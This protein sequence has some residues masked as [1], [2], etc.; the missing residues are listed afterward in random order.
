MSSHF[1]YLIED[2]AQD[3]FQK[4]AEER[5]VSSI[6]RDRPSVALETVKTASVEEPQ[7][8]FEKIAMRLDRDIEIIKMAGATGPEF[9]ATMRGL[10]YLSKVAMEAQIS[11][12]EYYEVMGKVAYET[13]NTDM[14]EARAQ[15]RLVHAEEDWDEVDVELGKVAFEILDGM[16]KE[17]FGARALTGAAKML[18]GATAASG[19]K[20]IRALG[21]PSVAD[22]VRSGAGNL[23]GYADR[24][25]SAAGR[26]VKGVGGVAAAT[27]AALGKAGRRIRS[28]PNVMR[29]RSAQGKIDRTAR[30]HNRVAAA[31]AEDVRRGKEITQSITPS[32]SAAERKAKVGELAHLRTNIDSRSRKMKDLAGKN[33]E[34]KAKRDDLIGARRSRKLEDAKQ[35]EGGRRASEATSGKKGKKG[36]EGKKGKKGKIDTSTPEAAKKTKKKAKEEGWWNSLS[37]TEKKQISMAAGAGLFA[38]H[39]LD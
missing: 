30:K 37:E 2:D 10:N 19:A 8:G 28:A 16:P 34:A 18:R 4:V 5:A 39:V 12:D 23:K 32:M 36:G 15:L 33:M 22:R 13:L 11:S 27:P 20:G 6:E 24:G 38:G 25:F 3:F 7:T 9:G 26:A 17:A 35:T 1:D 29:A 21:K 14:A 31:H